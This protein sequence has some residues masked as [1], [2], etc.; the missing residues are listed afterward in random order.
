MDGQ[1][2]TLLPGQS[3]KRQVTHSHGIPAG[4][5]EN[6]NQALLVENFP[7]QAL[8]VISFVV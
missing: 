5:T 7:Q 1:C 2:Q 3:M 8:E 4:G 6:R